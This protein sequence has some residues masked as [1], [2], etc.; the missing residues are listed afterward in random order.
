MYYQ[1]YQ[2]IESDG[3]FWKCK[4]KVRIAH[5][6]GKAKDL[7]LGKLVKFYFCFE[8]IQFGFPAR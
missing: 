6:F 1:Y 5:G 3:D 2:D 4:S 8:N 7:V